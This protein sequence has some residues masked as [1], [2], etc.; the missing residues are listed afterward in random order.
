[1]AEETTV[2]LKKVSAEG[3]EHGELSVSNE[4][5]GITP[6]IHVLHQ[7]MRREMA[8]GRAGT[9]CAKTRAEVRG[10]G[11]KPWKQKGTGR[12]RA[13]SIR[14]PL[15]AGG[16]VIFGPKPR[17]YSFALPRKVRMLA[18]RSSLSAAQ[19]KFRVFETFSFLDKP[20]T[21]AMATVFSTLGVEKG[22]RVLILVDYKNEENKALMLSARNLPGVKIRLPHNL[23]VQDLLGA[24]LVLANVEAIEEINERYAAYV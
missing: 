19:T 16:G 7:A 22:K 20:S 6:N 15:W 10:G 5:F 21:K 17:D 13:G 4:V 11:K 18:M 23:S 9:A 24:E 2:I 3:K 12:A 8:N 14:S 1:M